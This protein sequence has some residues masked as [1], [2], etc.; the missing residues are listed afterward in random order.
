MAKKKN[1]NVEKVDS[2]VEKSENGFYKGYDLRWLKR[3]TSHPKHYL[4]AE[5]EAVHGEV[6]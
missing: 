2:L 4:V 3:E 1:E 6:K 5:Y